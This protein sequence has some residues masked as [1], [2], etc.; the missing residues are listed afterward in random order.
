[1]AIYN[2]PGDGAIN[3]LNIDA[4]DVL[5]DIYT[6]NS[7]YQ[8]DAK[9]LFNPDLSKVSTGI[10]V[11]LNKDS[12]FNFKILNRAN[13]FLDESSMEV[14]TFF[15]GI[16]IDILNKNKQ[17][18]FDNFANGNLT[19][20][21]FLEQNNIE[22]FQS[23]NKEY[24]IRM[25]I[26]DKTS[27]SDHVSEYYVYGN[28]LYIKDITVQ[29]AA[30]IYFNKDPKN[31]QSYEPT[32][33]DNSSNEINGTDNPYYMAKSEFTLNNNNVTLS[34][35]IVFAYDLKEGFTIDWGDDSQDEIFYYNGNT[36]I[37]N[38]VTV[39][40]TNV[41]DE[42]F[43]SL[44]ETINGKTYE[45][46]KSHSYTVTQP[47]S[48]TVT[49]GVKESSSS[50]YTE[51]DSLDILLPNVM[52]PFGV[53]LSNSGV[54]GVINFDINFLNDPT[55]TNFDSVAIYASTSEN[56]T[57]SEDNLVKRDLIFSSD[58]QSQTISVAGE[59]IN[60]FQFY[61]FTIIPYS[62]FGSGYAWNIGPYTLSTESG[63]EEETKE[64]LDAGLLT[65][66]GDKTAID[67]EIEEYYINENP[68]QIDYIPT[69]FGIMSC[70]YFINAI[71]RNKD[72]CS[73]KLILTNQS[74]NENTT[75]PYHLTQYA[76]SDNQFIDYFVEEGVVN[77]EGSLILYAY[78][79][80]IQSFLTVEKATMGYDTGILE[81]FFNL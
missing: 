27:I 55:Y 47:T 4:D 66:L 28:N 67:R 19:S 5:T 63:E 13:D 42:N 7:V 53:Q 35:K 74:E 43:S 50:E 56:F 46:T 11:I 75:N 39:T 22:I 48:Y 76:I 8:F 18:V 54:N 77:D 60:Y 31:F 71:N 52:S 12:T 65:I 40:N 44:G 73:T 51:G 15:E 45:F 70:Q 21:S 2:K 80:Q 62:S 32:I 16:K 79:E 61:W 81:D 24:G 25:S 58:G 23:L 26:D 33:I 37:G 38:G 6:N 14:D 36:F 20:L 41:N 9:Y 57:I 29:A 17:K 3:E 34:V 64:S 49:H 59:D 10:S 78:P 30:G 1:M 68:I 72:I 69:G